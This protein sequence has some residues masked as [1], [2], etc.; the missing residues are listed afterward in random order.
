[1]INAANLGEI[2]RPQV[3]GDHV[4][5]VDLSGPAPVEWTA[6]AF[7]AAIDTRAA[8]LRA[9]DLPA[10]ARIGLL[11]GN[12]AA[13]LQ[14][15]FAV[16]RAGFVV[17]PI[18]HRLAP[19]TIAF[20]AQDAALACCLCDDAMAPLC[21]PGLAKM[22][23]AAEVPPS[24]PVTAA[25]AADA[26]AKILY[27][28]GSTGKPKGVVLDHAGQAWAIRHAMAAPQAGGPVLV[29]APF[30][31]KNG[32]FNATMALANRVPLVLLPG[33]D[34]R[35]YL[36]AVARY[37]VRR[38]TGVPTM[39]ALM[40]RETDLRATLDLSCVTEASV[41]SAP[42]S[43]ALAGQIAAMFPHARLTNGYGT[44]EA[45]PIVFAS[46][47]AG[48]AAPATALGVP[49][50]AIEWRLAGG[51]REGVLQLRTPAM[52]L[53]YLN[54]P[55]MTA[56]KL[57]DG[58]YD[59]GDIMRIDDAGLFH[60]VGRSDDMF[61]CG[62]ENIF[63]AEVEMLMERHPDVAQAAVVPAPDHIKGQV[64]V[65]FVV[66][67]NGHRP[68]PEALKRFALAEGPAYSH[69][70]AIV[71]RESLPLATTHKIDRQ[72]LMAEAAALLAER[73]RA[74]AHS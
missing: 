26:P 55:A 62:G 47:P 57:V 22:S 24:P 4:A 59:T 74:E 2:V 20:I 23:I 30:Y 45:G 35:R 44:T 19:A 33:F 48:V 21:P 63:P 64:P 31:H 52:M 37:R 28:S 73:N 49:D 39:F 9:L 65:A 10:G 66:P 51:A 70:R 27:T 40:A 41:G 54:E 60:F 71:V 46:S 38:V 67:R 29:A 13:T 43:D 6:A 56:R 11:A 5:V 18:N 36:E 69:P 42:L 17:V 53:G 34:A 1:M 32:L 25:I 61:V 3:A 16:M 72:L 12:S 68:D 8:A 14:A 7:D 58:W 15:Y 50:P